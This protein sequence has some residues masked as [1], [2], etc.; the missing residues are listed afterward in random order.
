LL[1][2]N[3]KVQS[4]LLA[5]FKL[6]EGH[7]EAYLARK[8]TL[9]HYCLLEALRLQPVICEVDFTPFLDLFVNRY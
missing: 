2:D 9:L 1:A 8:D 4:D 7:L 6:E 3:A 5:E